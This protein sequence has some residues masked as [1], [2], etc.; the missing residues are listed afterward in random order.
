MLRTLLSLLFA[1]AISAAQ[2]PAARSVQEEIAFAETGGPISLARDA[3]IYRFEKGKPVKIREGSNGC[4]CFVWTWAPGV[5]EPTCYDPAA[6]RVVMPRDMKEAALYA[7]GKNEDELQTEVGR[8]FV[9]GEL[10]TPP[11][12]AVIYMMSP[13]GKINRKGKLVGNEPHVMISVPYMK[14]SEIGIFDVDGAKQQGIPYI[15]HEGSV[16]AIIIVDVHP[17]QHQGH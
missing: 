8:A 2:E 4:A 1:A 5:E 10:Q 6:T 17:S 3:T 9:T 7:Q 12:G 11:K 14:N 15:N 13:K 16:D